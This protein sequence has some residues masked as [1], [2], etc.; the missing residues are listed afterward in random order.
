VGVGAITSF[1]SVILNGI[2]YQTTHTTISIDGKVASQGDL[3]V[4]DF[5]EVHGHHDQ[6][7]NQDIADQIEFRGNVEGPV[8]AIDVANEMPVV[9]GQTIIVSAE[10]SFEDSISPA[11]LA[12]IKVGAVGRSEQSGSGQG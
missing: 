8:S 6:N 9:L 1:G 4:G 12:G 5:I 10:T 11:G 3:H 7:S 2:E